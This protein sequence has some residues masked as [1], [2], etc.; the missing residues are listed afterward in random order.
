[1][2]STI[3]NKRVVME[4]VK[5]HAPYWKHRYPSFDLGEKLNDDEFNAWGFKECHDCAI[6]AIVKSHEDER[7]VAHILVKDVAEALPSYRE[8]FLVERVNL[9]AA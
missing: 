1:M 4:I 6:E 8:A 9:L 5:K 2:K 7:G 3:I